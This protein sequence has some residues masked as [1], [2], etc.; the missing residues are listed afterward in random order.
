MLAVPCRSM[1]AT[2]IASMIKKA[3][4]LIGAAEREQKEKEQGKEVMRGNPCGKPWGC[5]Q[6]AIYGSK[7]GEQ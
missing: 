7:R 4:K 5:R 6:T 1:Y 3:R 2:N